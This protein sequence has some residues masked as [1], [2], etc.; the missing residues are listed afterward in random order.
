MFL[1]NDSNLGHFV[2]VKCSR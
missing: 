1:G 2:I